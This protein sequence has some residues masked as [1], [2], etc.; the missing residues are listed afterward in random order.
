MRGQLEDLE[1]AGASRLARADLEPRPSSRM[2]DTELAYVGLWIFMLAYYLRPEDWTSAARFLPLAII[3]G[4][5]ALFGLARAYIKSGKLTRTTE[6]P[7]LL[8][9]LIWFVILVP[10][11]SWPGGS[12]EILES[13]I[14]KIS[15][16]SIVFINVIDSLKRL[17]WL[18]TIQAVGVTLI[19]L[20]SFGH[21]DQ[22][23]GRLTGKSQ[24]FGNSN[25]LASMIAITLPICAYM[26]IS[27]SAVKKV[28]WS[29]ASILMVFILV[30]TFS[31]TGFLAL[32]AAI[33]SLSWHFLVKQRKYGMLTI[34]ILA[35]MAAGIALPTQYRARVASIFIP[36]LDKDES[37]LDATGSRESRVNLLRRSVETTIAH[38]FMGVGPGQFQVVS[39]DWHGSHN[40]FLQLATETGIPGLVIFLLLLHVAFKNLRTAEQQVQIGFSSDGWALAGVLRASLITFVVAAFFSDF[41]YQFFTYFLFAY[42]ASL[43][44][45]VSTAERVDEIDFNLETEPR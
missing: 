4:G 8:A 24:A 29:V 21:I 16:L 44:Q 10:F 20:S 19:A 25:D 27:S 2:Y 6:V 18:L 37:R 32:A 26:I 40:T 15:L 42:T 1:I 28:I 45:I 17:R 30:T 31:R 35:T 11:S 14:W 12:F 13:R 3:G 43:N 7:L 33:A 22:S 9:F 39:G 5:L 38:P 23:S 36:S 34:T 41:G